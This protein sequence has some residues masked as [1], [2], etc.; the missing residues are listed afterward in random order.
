MTVLKSELTLDVVAAA[1]LDI[2]PTTDRVIRRYAIR[3]AET[4]LANVADGPVGI[5]EAARSLHLGLCESPDP[6]APPHP[7]EMHRKEAA[8]LLSAIEDPE[9]PARAAARKKAE[10]AGDASAS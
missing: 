4:F 8:E 3:W 6:D 5:D 7:W 9:M 10:P 1:F 2:Q